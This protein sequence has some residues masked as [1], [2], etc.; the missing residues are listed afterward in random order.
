MDPVP[1]VGQHNR[2]ILTDLGYTDSEIDTLL[3]SPAL[4]GV[5]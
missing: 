4:T 2:D 5:D 1:S 3:A